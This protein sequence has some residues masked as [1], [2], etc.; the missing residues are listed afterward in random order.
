MVSSSRVNGV[1]VVIILFCFLL[2]QNK[3]CTETGIELRQTLS[4]VYDLVILGGATHDWSLRKLFGMGL[5]GPCPLAQS[6]TIFI[7]I[8]SNQVK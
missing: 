1:T 2:L 8:T 4:L 3:K 5:G 6:S 7:D